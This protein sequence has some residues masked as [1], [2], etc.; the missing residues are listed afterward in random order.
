MKDTITLS[1]F[2]KKEKRRLEDDIVRLEQKKLATIIRLNAL[3]YFEAYRR[4]RAGKNA[5]YTLREHPGDYSQALGW[6]I[7]RKVG[8]LV[9]Q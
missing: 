5:H 1:Q 8:S 2:V 6:F 4:E 9:C 7:E 3:P